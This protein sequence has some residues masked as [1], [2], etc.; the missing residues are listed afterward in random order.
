MEYI[1]KL[2]EFIQKLFVWWVIVS[3]WERGLRVRRGKRVRVLEEGMHL[4]IPFFDQIFIQAIRL[5]V[6]SMPPQTVSTRDGKTLTVVAAIGYSITDIEK[7]YQTLS[8]PESTLCNLVMGHI[9]EYVGAHGFEECTP[10]LIE[11]EATLQ[12]EK[13]QFGIRFEYLRITGYA[14]VKTYRLIQDGHWIPND[15]NTSQPAK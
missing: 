14:V 3:P 4:R 6:V 7:V 8:H 5:R 11:R 1:G 12:L 2:L 15:L 9:A 13:S 10:A